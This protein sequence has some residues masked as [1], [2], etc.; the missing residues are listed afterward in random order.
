M[1]LI[2]ARSLDGTAYGPTPG[3]AVAL[4]STF[5]PPSER[6]HAGAVRFSDPSPVRQP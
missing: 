2:V 1:I 3:Y 5:L 4:A 6:G